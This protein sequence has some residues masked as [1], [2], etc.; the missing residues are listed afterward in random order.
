MKQQVTEWLK[1]HDW[2]FTEKAS[3]AV[4]AFLGPFLLLTIPVVKTSVDFENTFSRGEYLTLAGAAL[5]TLLVTHLGRLLYRDVA[6]R[7]HTVIYVFVVIVLLGLS[8]SLFAG[9]FKDDGEFSALE[10]GLAGFTIDASATMLITAVA[11]GLLAPPTRAKPDPN[12]A[13]RVEQF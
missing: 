3:F 1:E 9:R 5:C 7:V 13:D 11:V 6:F 10:Y 12:A 4:G 2:W 8:V